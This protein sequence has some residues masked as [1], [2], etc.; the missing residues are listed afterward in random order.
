MLHEHTEHIGIGL[1]SETLCIFNLFLKELPFPP[2]YAWLQPQ[3][4]DALPLTFPK[5]EGKETY[6]ALLLY[7]SRSLSPCCTL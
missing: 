6:P 3:T 7:F 2:I 5:P 1:P 4:S